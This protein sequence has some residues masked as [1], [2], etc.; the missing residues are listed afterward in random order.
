MVLGD[1][2]REPTLFEGLHDLTDAITRESVGV[3]VSNGFE[4]PAD[5]PRGRHGV[6]VHT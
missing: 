6:T 4:I 5:S 2:L 1:I 3:V